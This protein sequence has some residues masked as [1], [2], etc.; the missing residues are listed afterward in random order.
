MAS[1]KRNIRYY[2][3]NDP[4][5]WEVDNLPLTDLLNND[6][7]LEGRID[8]L[9]ELLS[10]ITTG[11]GT[12]T[13]NA[14]ADLKAYAV[15]LSDNSSDFGKV[16]VRPGKFTARMQLPATRERGWR[17]MRD[18]NDVFNNN[19]IA[20]TATELGTTDLSPFVRG[21]RGVAR[22]SVVEFYPQVT[23]KD[24]FVTIES[25]NAED[26]NSNSSPSERLD[27]IYIKGSKALDTDGDATFTV[28]GILQDSLPPAELG[29]IKGAYFRTD[30][31]GGT[32]L[33]GVRFQNAVSRINGKITGM[34]Q[35]QM[36][37]N[38]NLAGFGSVPMPEDLVNYAW[39][40][41]NSNQEGALN[42]AE[43]QVET[44]ALF[45]LPIAYVRVPSNYV[46]GDPIP[47]ENIID[48][49]PFLRTA[50][51]TLS[52]RQGIAASWNPNGS[53]PFVTK[54]HFLHYFTPLS[55][56]VDEAEDAIAGNT[57]NI[58]SNTSQ[59]NNLLNRTISLENSVSGTN[60]VSNASSLNHEG[61][62]QALEL[63]AGNTNS[64]AIEQTKFLANSYSI[65][66]DERVNNLGTDAAPKVWS[67]SAG[68]PGADRSKVIAI[69]VTYTS[70]GG[71]SDADSVNI[72]YSRGGVQTF[73]RVSV[74]GVAQSG[75]DLRRNWGNTN[76]VL[77][78][79]TLVSA[80]GGTDVRIE[81]KASGSSDVNHS[82]VL[83]GYIIRETVGLG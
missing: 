82:A 26:F 16:F 29:V 47:P 6:V 53:N 37:A 30:A 79:P 3:P 34:G 41:S 64:I 5:Y 27:L 56:R 23:G 51:L 71:G 18:D 20:G 42:L 36:P 67:L 9:T 61:R 45:A 28:S 66:T 46:Q 57:G 22:T 80:D 73:N 1:I 81:T 74:W 11:A 49:R 8:D 43:M 48:I 72:L 39:H 33:N 69:M 68:I 62:I 25:F 13:L 63:G 83:T 50:E 59:L 31:A 10:D 75:G 17:M 55:N 21:S 44:Q 15:G 4:Y 58:A 52:E 19:N 60:A 38:T 32:R 35:N 70:E 77:Q 40:P 7:I 24:K 76:S 12:L 65:F 78:P 54:S 14:I 2:Q